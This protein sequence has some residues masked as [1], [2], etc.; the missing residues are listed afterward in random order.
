MD[1]MEDTAVPVRLANHRKTLS[2]CKGLKTLFA[3]FD[4]DLTAFGA[5]NHQNCLY[6]LA[7]GRLRKN[8]Q[9]T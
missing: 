5:S 7:T 8:E 6:R 9:A 3:Q 4:K 1:A 2:K